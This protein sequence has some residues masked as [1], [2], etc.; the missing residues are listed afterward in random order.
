MSLLKLAQTTKQH[1]QSLTEG[2]RLAFRGLLKNSQMQTAISRSAVDGLSGER[3]EDIER[4]Q[5]FGFTSHCPAGADVVVLPLGGDSSHCVIISDE[6]QQYRIQGLAPGEV[7]VYD[8]SGSKIVLKQGRLIEI[9][10]DVLHIKASSQVTIDSPFVQ[11]S[12]VLT[13]QGQI[14]GNGGLA[15][16]GGSG[17]K[18]TGDIEHTGDFFNTGNITNN[19]KNIGSSHQHSETNGASTGGVL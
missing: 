6:H 11:T 8:Q 1:A 5:S 2:M 18:F 12:E 10:C 13:A 4:L 17:A 3:L 14:N 9:D 16:Q 19:G 7:A 15:I